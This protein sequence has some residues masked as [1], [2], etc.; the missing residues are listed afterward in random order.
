M[1]PN[2]SDVLASNLANL[3]GGQASISKEKDG[4]KVNLC[5]HNCYPLYEFK[6]DESSNDDAISGTIYGHQG[7]AVTDVETKFS[8]KADGKAAH[9]TVIRADG[10]VEVHDDHELKTAMFHDYVVY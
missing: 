9:L 1:N 6:V 8:L 3:F 10:N 7:A 5:M 2:L 4:S